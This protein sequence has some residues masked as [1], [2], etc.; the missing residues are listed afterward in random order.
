AYGTALPELDGAPA[1]RARIEKGSAL[2]TERL[3]GG[4]PV[5]G[6]TTGFGASSKN[7]VSP[8]LATALAINLVRY[9][10]CGTGA[11]LGEAESAAIL[12]ARLA[13]LARGLSGVRLLVLERLRD[14][15]RARILPRIPSEGSVGASGDLT[16]LSYVAAAIAGEREVTAFGGVMAAGEALARAGIEPVVLGPKESLALMNGTSMMTGLACLVHARAGRLVRLGAALTAIAV[17][18]TAGQPGH[19]D[20]RIFAAKPHPGQ[21]ACARWI[22]EDIESGSQ[23]VASDGRRQDRYSIRCAPHVLGV[24]ADFLPFA[25]RTIEV[26]VNGAND[27]PLIDLETGDVLHGGNFYGGHIA[28]VMD[29][30]K[31]AVASVADLLDRQ[32]VQLGSP[33]TSGGLP[34]NLVAVTGAGRAAHHGFKAMEVA[35]SALTA[36]ALKA[37]MPAAAFSRSTEGHNQDKVSMGSIAARD[38]LR[39]MELSETVAAIHLLALCQAFDLREGRGCNKRARALHAAVR[40]QVPMNVADRRQDEDIARVLALLRSDALPIGDIDLR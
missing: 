20:A 36:E 16:P 18:V 31:A 37:T 19:F 4:R 1:F 15:L 32:L 26:E 34:E 7:E 30:M 22:R 29:A 35:S 8:E 9:H 11:V 10:G 17:D 38:A 33:Q 24:L 40:E 12:A 6:V 28:F 39:V 2:V 25:R 3:R 13:S 5:Y 14:L 23:P 27:N 21:E